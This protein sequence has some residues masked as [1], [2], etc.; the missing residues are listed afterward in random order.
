MPSS[1]EAE[2]GSMVYTGLKMLLFLMFMRW[3]LAP[4]QTKA[5]G[6][7]HEDDT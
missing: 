1:A 2:D 4:E 5:K 3:G 6:T 7:H